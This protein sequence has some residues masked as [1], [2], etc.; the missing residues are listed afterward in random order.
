MGGGRGEFLKEDKS[1]WRFGIVALVVKEKNGMLAERR[2]GTEEAVR[3][4][5]WAE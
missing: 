5:D 3:R 1:G 4:R 2:S